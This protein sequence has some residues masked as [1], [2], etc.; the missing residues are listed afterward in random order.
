MKLT[1]EEGITVS[2][3]FRLIA[4]KSRVFPD[5]DKI[6]TI[7]QNILLIPENLKKMVIYPAYI[8]YPTILLRK[9]G[10]VDNNMPTKKK[11]NDSLAVKDGIY[12]IRGNL[13]SNAM[14]EVP[15][16]LHNVKEW[17][18]TIDWT[19]ND[20]FSVIVNIA[21]IYKSREEYLN[22]V[23]DE[24]VATTLNDLFP[25]QGKIME[26]LEKL[27]QPKDDKDNFKEIIEENIPEESDSDALGELPT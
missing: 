19:F 22:S 6:G 8:T 25:R 1:N 27:E 13:Q 23:R 12:F 11:F 15:K 16:I 20:Y 2:G 9:Y 10:L 14:E 21:E 24:I 17:A 5:G 3:Q 4:Q 26:E 7:V 18:N